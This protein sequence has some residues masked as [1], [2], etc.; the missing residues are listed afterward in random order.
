MPKYALKANVEN[1]VELTSYIY[2]K[3]KNFILLLLLS[4]FVAYGCV[5][6]KAKKRKSNKSK[7]KRYKSSNGDC[8]CG[9]TYMSTPEEFQKSGDES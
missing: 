2:Y 8:N 7:S 6:Q 3:M 9:H 4:T 5:S 1:H